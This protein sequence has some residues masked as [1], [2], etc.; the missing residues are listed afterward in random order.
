MKRIMKYLQKRQKNN[1][2]ISDHRYL[3]F[4]LSGKQYQGKFKPRVE[5]VSAVVNTHIEPSKIVYACI[6]CLGVT[7]S[8]KI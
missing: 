1:H 3:G 7:D 6:F 5:V 8:W 2:C 4:Y